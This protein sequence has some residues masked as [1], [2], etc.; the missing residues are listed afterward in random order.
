MRY[1]S[2]R[3][4]TALPFHQ[5]AINSPSG[6]NTDFWVRGGNFITVQIKLNLTQLSQLAAK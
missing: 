5:L 6:I 4:D 3:S 2:C 1:G